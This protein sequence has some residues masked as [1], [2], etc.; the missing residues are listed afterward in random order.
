ML[1]ENGGRSALRP[2]VARTPRLS[3]KSFALAPRPG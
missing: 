1:H 3:A 2:G